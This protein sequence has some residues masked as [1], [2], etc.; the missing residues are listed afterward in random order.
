MSTCEVQ[1]PTCKAESGQAYDVQ[2]NGRLAEGNMDTY[3]GRY[4][5]A[6]RKLNAIPADDIAEGM[7]ITSSAIYNIERRRD[8][9]FKTGVRYEAALREAVRRRAMREEQILSSG[10]ADLAA[11]PIERRIEFLPAVTRCRAEAGRSARLQR[12][13]RPVHPGL[14]VCD[15]HIERHEALFESVVRDMYTRE[16]VAR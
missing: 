16:R 2:T 4:L 9:G 11:L 14:V 5:A 7:G 6:R 1:G 10:I 12:C 13:G 15:E 8:V 3:D